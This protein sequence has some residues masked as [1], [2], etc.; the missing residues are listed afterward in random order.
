MESKNGIMK[1]LELNGRSILVTI[2]VVGAMTAG[3]FWLHRSSPGLG[4]GKYE[5]FGLTFEYPLLFNAFDAGFLDPSAGANDFMG[6]AEAKGVWEDVFH[7]YLVV[8]TTESSVP[9]LEDILEGVYL[10]LADMDSVIDGK[11]P[12]VTTEKDGHEMLYQT[13]TLTQGEYDFIGTFGVWYEPWSSLRAYRVY[14]VSY[15]TFP[16][17]ATRPQVE[18]TFLWFTET[19]SS[20]SWE[21]SK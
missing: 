20:N 9:E 8:W 3:N 6:V 21:G 1:L 16:D 14:V 5:N 17:A 10:W 11:E 13:I 4:Y 18:E 19:V 2:I 15:I 7:N 12:M